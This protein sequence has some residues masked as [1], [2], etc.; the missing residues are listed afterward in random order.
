MNSYNAR[1][2][3]LHYTYAIATKGLIKVGFTSYIKRRM[4]WYKTYDKDFE[5]L[6]IRESSIASLEEKELIN[7]MK[8]KVKGN[9]W[10]KDTPENR[11]F[12]QRYK[13]L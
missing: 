8:D 7:G 1:T 2:N 3:R 5:V 6:M 9:E 12:L 4:N 13:L 10:F 11:A